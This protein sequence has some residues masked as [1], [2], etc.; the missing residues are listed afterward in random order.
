MKRFLRRLAA[1]VVVVLAVAGIAGYVY[2]HPGRGPKQDVDASKGY[3]ESIEGVTVLHLKGSPYELG[4]EHGALCRDRVTAGMNA[5][6]SLLNEAHED[7]HI[8]I[9][10]LNF[11]LDCVYRMCSPYIPD[12]YK[13]ELEGLAD[14]AGVDLAI[15]RRV[16]VISEVTE[17]NCTSFAVFGNATTDGRLLHGHNFDWDT[18]AGIQN[19]AALF[20]YEPDEGIPF[21]AF[22]YTGMIGYVSGMNME[23]VSVGFIGAVTR[24]GRSAAMPLML[25]LRHV[26]ENAHNLEEAGDLIEHAHRGVG[27]NYVIADG[28]EKDARAFET[29]A[30]HF[31]D[32]GP[33]DPKETCE[34]A[35]RIEDAL[36]RADEAMDPTV[37]S[38][39]KCS[40]GYPN[41][42]YG[43]GSYER[44]KGQADGIRAA[45]GKIDPD[46]AIEILQS[47][48]MRGSNLHSV[49]CDTTNRVLWAACAKGDQDA[50]TQPYHR[51][52]LKELFLPPD[53]RPQ[54]EE[55]ASGTPASL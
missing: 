7:T 29:T 14:G 10:V 51:F 22:G 47:V 36:F 1:G 3:K 5:Y 28:D 11:G 35:I 20:L 30:R 34:Y 21:A 17:R 6:H 12:Q 49:L 42:P 24:D 33:N 19:T 41:L 54:H 53:Q 48:A 37:R 15:L 32:F 38:F 44:Y 27:Y 23:G 2:A 4:F 46:A 39:Q 31:A 26:L 8:P 45:Y 25:M 40:N 55:A 43:S 18:S 13:R 52:D 9:W 16:H 50:C